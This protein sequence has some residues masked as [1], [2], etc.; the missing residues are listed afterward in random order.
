MPYFLVPHLY[1]YIV[2][3]SKEKRKTQKKC[4]YLFSMATRSIFTSSD[5]VTIQQTNKAVLKSV[6]IVLP[7][8]M[9]ICTC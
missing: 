8:Y 5:N 6:T 4:I 2:N 1:K 9:I 7:Y 3:R